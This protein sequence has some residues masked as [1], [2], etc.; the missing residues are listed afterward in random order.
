MISEQSQFP[1]YQQTV[2]T[3]SRPVSIP[4]SAQ[5]QVFT[6]KSTANTA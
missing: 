5:L 6:N 3:P 2:E 1:N 4:S